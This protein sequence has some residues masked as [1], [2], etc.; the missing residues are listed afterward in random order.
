MSTDSTGAAQ[1]KTYRIVLSI[2]GVVFVEAD[3]HESVDDVIRFYRGDSVHAEYAK[4]SVKDFAEDPTMTQ[5]IAM[6]RTA[7]RERG[8]D[9]TKNPKVAQVLDMCHRFNRDFTLSEI[10]A[11]V[12]DE[13]AELALESS[14]S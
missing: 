6:L 2:G 9:L 11:R 14:W 3:S 10:I 1:M 4:A 7:E 12:A 8:L 5:R 13:R